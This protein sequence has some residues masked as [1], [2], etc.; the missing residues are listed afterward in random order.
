[1]A[2]ACGSAIG[3]A[4]VKFSEKNNGWR[5]LSEIS[6]F[7]ARKKAQ[8]RGTERQCFLAGSIAAAALALAAAG[9]IQGQ[10]VWGPPTSAGG[11]FQGTI[12]TYAGNGTAGYQGDGKAALQAELKNPFGVALDSAATSISPT[13]PTTWCAR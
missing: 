2:M 5:R 4:K 1:M 7:C 11:V 8:G 12:V 6:R 13:P 10:V 9:P 3:S